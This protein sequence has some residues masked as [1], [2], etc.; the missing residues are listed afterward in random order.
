M[1]DEHA[2]SYLRVLAAHWGRVIWS[3]LSVLS[4][5]VGLSVVKFIGWP[6]VVVLVFVLG[7]LFLA[8]WRAW[9]AMRLERNTARETRKRIAAEQDDAITDF[10]KRLSRCIVKPV[11]SDA[12]LDG[13]IAEADAA[14]NEAGEWIAAHLSQSEAQRFLDVLS[15]PPRVHYG[16]TPG[17]FNA[18]H[19]TVRRNLSRYL[20]NLNVLIDRPP[21]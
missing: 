12:E 17:A 7:T 4:V 21:P 6:V 19:D 15:G 8:Q 16:S 14:V 10:H 11:S 5:L 2:E 9:D 13:L 20:E 18:K 1:A 3:A